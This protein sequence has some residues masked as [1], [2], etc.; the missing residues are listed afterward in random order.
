MIFCTPPFFLFVVILLALVRCS[1]IPS[2][3]S[4]HPLELRFKNNCASPVVEKIITAIDWVSYSYAQEHAVHFE[5]PKVV[6]RQYISLRL[7]VLRLFHPGATLKTAPPLMN[8]HKRVKISKNSAEYSRTYGAGL[9][10]TIFLPRTNARPDIKAIE[11]FMLAA[12][13]GKFIHDYLRLLRRNAKHMEPVLTKSPYWIDFS[14]IPSP[15]STERQHWYTHMTLKVLALSCMRRH[16]RSRLLPTLFIKVLTKEAFPGSITYN[17]ERLLTLPSKFRIVKIHKQPIDVISKSEVFFQYVDADDLDVFD[18][19]VDVLISNTGSKPCA[20]AHLLEEGHVY[21]NTEV[22][23]RVF[24]ITL[25]KDSL[26]S[27]SMRDKDT[28]FRVYLPKHLHASHPTPAMLKY[29]LDLDIR[30]HQDQSNPIAHQLLTAEAIV[31]LIFDYAFIPNATPGLFLVFHKDASHVELFDEGLVYLLTGKIVRQRFFE[32]KTRTSVAL[33]A[34]T[35]VTSLSVSKKG[36]RVLVNCASDRLIVIDGDFGEQLSARYGKMSTN[37]EFLQDVQ[38]STTATITEICGWNLALVLSTIFYNVG[39]DLVPLY[40]A[41][42]PILWG[43]LMFTATTKSCSLVVGSAQKRHITVPDDD[44]AEKICLRKDHD[45]FESTRASE[46]GGLLYEIR[47]YIDETDSMD[48]GDHGRQYFVSLESPFDMEDVVEA[49]Q[50]PLRIYSARGSLI[51]SQPLC[52]SGTF[53]PASTDCDALLDIPGMHRVRRYKNDILL[54][55]SKV[56]EKKHAHVLFK[57]PDLAQFS[58]I[59]VSLFP[60]QKNVQPIG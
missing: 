25:G 8:H 58:A 28:L 26:Q 34:E 31:G 29:I 37:G 5:H 42:F 13:S 1:F 17:L 47:A 3:K 35:E 12:P 10:E 7:K 44:N 50:H 19:P 14:R 16:A 53:T 59:A 55:V 36:T 40:G 22:T 57:S 6:A 30:F 15:R 51:H 27:S 4:Y 2:L 49:L 20:L 54:L 32:K 33:E 23:K 45:A 18:E 41:F 56:G 60:V 43:F 46:N 38:G 48:G 11:Q 24:A 9:T 21:S 39:S 52:S